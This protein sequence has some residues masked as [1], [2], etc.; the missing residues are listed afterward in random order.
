M[1][2]HSF[3]IMLSALVAFMATFTSRADYSSTIMS[4]NPVAYWPLNETTQPP[5]A[6]LATNSGTL[7][8]KASGYYGNMYYPDG[9]GF[10]LMTLFTGPVAG[11]TSD[12]DAAAQFN[13]GA[14]NNDNSGYVLI[15][16]EN[17][18]L[19]HAGAFTA[20][21]WVM[22]QGG[23]PNDPTGASYASTEWTSIIKKGG[24]GAYYTENG[25]VNGQT[26]GWTVA[27]AGKYVLGAPVGWY[28]G[29]PYTGPL[30]LQTNAC[31][32]V[33]F[34]NGGNGNTPSLEF[35]VPLN[36]PTP[37]WFH[38]VLAF[39]GTNANFYV[40]GVLTATTVPG[41]PQSTNHVF[42]PGAFPASSSGAY[43]FVHGQWSRLRP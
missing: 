17:R 16:D 18:D 6:Y 33:D 15:P 20:E 5:A 19:D 42:A 29:A 38:L 21:A 32:V 39:D 22:P 24:G 30:Q 10:D 35:D 7:G 31:W 23:D 34:Y 25:D 3:R 13:G 43:Q 40:N 1:N 37:Q 11:A 4:F 2:K 36:E 8:A 41:L 27:M 12:G 26:Y 9:T 28:G 14:N